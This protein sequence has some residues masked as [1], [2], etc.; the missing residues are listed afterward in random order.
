MIAWVPFSSLFLIVWI[1]PMLPTVCTCRN[2]SRSGLPFSAYS[3]MSGPLSNKV[4]FSLFSAV[5]RRE[6]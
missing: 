6:A 5:V 1:S 2:R 4:T 3:G